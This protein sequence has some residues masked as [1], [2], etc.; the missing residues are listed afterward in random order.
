M[1]EISR[2]ITKEA[3][4]AGIDQLFL[5]DPLIFSELLL[6]GRIEQFE[7]SNS[8]HGNKVFFDRGIPDIHAY[9]DYVGTAYPEIFFHRSRE[10]RYDKVFMTPPWKDIYKTDN[11]RYESYE[12]SLLIYEFLMNAYTR[13]NYDICVV[14]TGDVSLRVDFI[15]N[16]LQ[17]AHE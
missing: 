6:K 11:E 3:Q 5:N 15:L 9:L 12:Q 16:S 2:T 7:K 10:F 14:P 8:I 13:L 17:A 1:P 4:Q